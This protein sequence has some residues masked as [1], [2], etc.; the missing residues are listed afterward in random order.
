MRSVIVHGPGQVGVDTVPDPVLPGPDGAI[1]AV[2][3]AAICGSDLHFYDGDL[4]LFPVAVGHE[5]VGTVVEVGPDVRRTRPG[6]RVLVASVAGCGHCVGCASGDP[7]TC[8]SGGKVF[9]AGELGGGQSDLLAVPAA[10]FQLLPLPEAIDDEAALL[11]TDNLGT[12]WAGAQRA[13][14]PPGGTVVVLG[15]GAVGLCAVRSALLLGAGQ[16]LAVDPVAGRR[17][18]AAASGATPVDGPTVEAVLE[19]TGGRG[20]DAVIDAVATNGSMDDAFAAVRAGG[21]ISVIGIHDLEP[22]PLPLLM[23]VFRSITLR[24]TTAP[25]HRSW[26]DLVPLVQH[27]RL[28]TSGI[29]THAFDLDD[30]AAAYAAVAARSADCV[31][32]RLRVSD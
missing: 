32:V 18:R 8:L 9:G 22:Y 7:V 4:P 28:D 24:M 10:D 11:L 30:A 1:V 14:I 17:E 29:F 13:D 27:G 15:L 23:G 19:A 26:T 5:V 21:T 16:V 6:D 25:V 3:S 2:G 12:G 20:A 31:K